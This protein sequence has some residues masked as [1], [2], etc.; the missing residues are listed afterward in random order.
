M[1][2]SKLRRKQPLSLLF[3]IRLLVG[4]LWINGKRFSTSGTVFITKICEIS[5]PLPNG[6][7]AYYNILHW[8]Q[9]I[10]RRFFI[11]I[12]LKHVFKVLIRIFYL[13][14]FVL[15]LVVVNTS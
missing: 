12:I 10:E 7:F 1:E 4:L 5:L 13:H 14:T 15:L 9:L 11:S 3:K 6:K 8:S 2:G